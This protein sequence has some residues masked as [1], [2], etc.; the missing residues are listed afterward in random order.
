VFVQKRDE[1]DKKVKCIF[2]HLTC[3]WKKEKA[4]SNAEAAF[5]Y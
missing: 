1:A 2:Y 5:S 4:A 3:S